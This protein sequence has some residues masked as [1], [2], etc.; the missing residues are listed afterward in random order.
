[1]M[2]LGAGGVGELGIGHLS[3]LLLLISASS[4]LLKCIVAIALESTILLERHILYPLFM[5]L[6]HTYS[7]TPSSNWL[8]KRHGTSE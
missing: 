7:L 3:V 2:I 6:S 5:I 1:M 4:R 8:Q